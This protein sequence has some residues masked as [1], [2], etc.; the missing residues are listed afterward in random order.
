M[1]TKSGECSVAFERAGDG[2][3]GERVAAGPAAPRGREEALGGCALLV[4]DAD[5]RRHEVPRCARVRTTLAWPTERS[6]PR[7]I[8][9][10]MCDDSSVHWYSAVH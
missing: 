7:S 8:L 2:A 4:L 10:C 9:Y 3:G 6:R 1:I 5:R